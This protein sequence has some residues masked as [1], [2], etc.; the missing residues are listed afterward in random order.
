MHIICTRSESTPH[1]G[2]PF[3]VT[4]TRLRRGWPDTLQCIDGQDWQPPAFPQLRC[5]Q[6][7]MVIAALRQPIGMHWHRAQRCAGPWR[8]NYSRK[9]LC[10]QW[11]QR[12]TPPVFKGVDRFT[13]GSFVHVA[14]HDTGKQGPILGAAL[15]HPGP[16]ERRGA[17]TAHR[18]A[19]R[20]KG[21]ATRGAQH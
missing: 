4:Q 15:A 9:G 17:H 2:Q 20:H 5:Q 6:A 21:R 12:G 14:A 1:I 11:G 10:Q 18:A 8:F 19:Q 13:Q 3:C 16:V 7:S